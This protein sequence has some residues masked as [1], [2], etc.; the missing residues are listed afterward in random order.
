M[1]N[2]E[3]AVAI[4]VGDRQIAGTVIPPHVSLEGFLFVHGWAGNQEQ[5][6]VRAR[7]MAALGC[8]SLTI[9]LHGHAATSSFLST[10]T[11]DE[12]LADVLAAYDFLAGLSNVNE[13]AIGLVGSSYGAYL[14]AI[15]T[16]LRA[17]RWLVLRA[18]ALYRDE[19]WEK[20]K[21]S[22]NRDDLMAYRRMKLEARGNRALEA[23]SQFRGDVLLVES[24]HDDIVPAS[25]TANYRTAFASARSVTVRVIEG[26]DHALSEKSWQ[27]AYTSLLMEWAKEVV[28]KARVPTLEARDLK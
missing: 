19:H 28:V 10:V 12:N 1:K 5:Y 11:R 6:L 23:C 27:D 18:P 20:P 13:S 16:A 22:L 26:A 9:D 14:S 17:V 3:Q 2:R 4:K 25:V 7:E 24:E 8:M 21:Q 15:V